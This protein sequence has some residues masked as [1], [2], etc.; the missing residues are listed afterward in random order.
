ME[1]SEIL[2]GLI[3]AK[4]KSIQLFSNNKSIII[5]EL[6]IHNGNNVTYDESKGKITLGVD[7]LTKNEKSLLFNELPKQLEGFGTPILETGLNDSLQNYKKAV[8]K[9]ENKELIK[10]LKN[11][12]PHEDWLILNTS[13][14]LREVFANGGACRQN[15]NRYY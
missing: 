12:L 2:K 15:K 5:K 3:Q 7:S 1:I 6:H 9:I 14:Y 11:K 10:F 8:D 13:I 4:F